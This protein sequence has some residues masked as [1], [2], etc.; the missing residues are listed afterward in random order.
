MIFSRL[1]KITFIFIFIIT[2]YAYGDDGK[3]NRIE[4]LVNEN[5]ITKYD[6]FQRMKINSILKRTEINDS[7]YNQ[8]LN[9]IIDDLVVEKLKMK[10]IDEYNINF[11][12]DEFD[13]Y[14]D[15]FYSRL[16]YEKEELNELF[17]LNNINFNN[18][19]EL[20]EIEL[21]WQKLIYGLY[22][23]VTSVTEQELDDVM[24]KNPNISKETA[25][26][27]ILQ[28]QL[29]IKSIKLIKDLRDEATI[30]YK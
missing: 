25:T 13:I 4:V 15:R 23:R 11:D 14:E 10:K 28:K 16:D 17:T 6:I 27:I 3:F 24:A 19:R 7:N 8:L 29:D 18:L 2:S 22:L 5:V 21:R 26:D 9:I 30:E 12:S 20:I 1:I